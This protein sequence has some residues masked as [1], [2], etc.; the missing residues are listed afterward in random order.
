MAT[1]H[2]ISVTRGP[3]NNIGFLVAMAFFQ[4]LH[5]AWSVGTPRA[6]STSSRGRKRWVLKGVLY[7]TTAG[8]VAGGLY[9]WRA[10]PIERRKMRVTVEGGVRFLR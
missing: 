9:Y 1:K 2:M 4:R 6:L 7:G 3:L 5:G 8:I 10:S